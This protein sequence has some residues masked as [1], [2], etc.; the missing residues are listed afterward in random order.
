MSQWLKIYATR[1][2]AEAS[3]VQGL[4]RENEIPVQIMNKMDS[5]YLNFGD[6]EVYVPSH[7]KDVARELLNQALLN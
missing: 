6:I 5:S 4:L 2:P 7:L 3:I 1:N